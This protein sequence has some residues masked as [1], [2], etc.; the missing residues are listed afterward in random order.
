M[1]IFSKTKREKINFLI[2]GCG[3]FGLPIV[4]SL[5]DQNHAVTVIDLHSESFSKIPVSLHTLLIEGDGTDIETL[6]AAGIQA[7]DILIAV[8][9]DDAVNIMIT[10][11]AK[12]KYHISAAISRICDLDRRGAYDALGIDAVSPVELFT[13]K[14]LE[15][16]AAGNTEA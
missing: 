11:L 12:E 15:R 7:A 10:Q 8:T 3:H 4:K 5:I 13:G 6:E 16:L 9:N 2:V 14:C 1:K